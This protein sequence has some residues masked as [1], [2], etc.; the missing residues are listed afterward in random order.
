M[1]IGYAYVVADII[2]IGHLRHLQACRGLCDKLIVGVLTDQATMERKPKP[3]LSFDERL[4]ITRALSF[5]DVAVKQEDYSPLPNVEQ[6]QPDILFE[7]TSHTIK[8]LIKGRK[9]V[10]KYGGRLIA[11]PYY[12]EQ[13]S[14][15]IKNTIL[16]NWVY[17][18]EIF[19]HNALLK[20]DTNDKS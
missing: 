9:V 2:H 12:A 19:P 3:I 8:D 14:S 10:K 20:G 15:A 6:L 4:K 1:Q 5:V 16:K 7:S 18:E 17:K 13:S 11:M